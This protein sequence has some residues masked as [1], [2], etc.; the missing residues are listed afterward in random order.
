MSPCRGELETTHHAR[1]NGNRYQVEILE[2]L[3]ICTCHIVGTDMSGRTGALITSFIR[4]CLVY[5]D[6]FGRVLDNLSASHRGSNTRDIRFTAE[7]GGDVSSRL[8]VAGDF[9]P[10]RR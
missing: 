1:T 5:V 10:H 3:G 7:T 9:L 4:N 2:W 8:G 6:I